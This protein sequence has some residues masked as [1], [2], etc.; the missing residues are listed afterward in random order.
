[1][2]E[3]DHAAEKGHQLC[4][5]CG[6]CCNGVIFADVKLQR[7]DNAEELRSLGVKLTA[8]PLRMG[9]GPGAARSDRH[10]LRFGQPCA[11]LEGCRCT[12]YAK[13]PAYCRDFECILLK[14]VND[15][16][17]SS[18]AALR[19][20]QDARKRAERVKSLLE[21]LGDSDLDQPLAA[22]FQRIAS[23]IHK[24]NLSEERAEL[25]GQLTLAVH[26]LNCLL[27][28]AFYR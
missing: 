10:T 25:Y 27:A 8:S 16:R 15:N 14:N 18:S 7:S 22:R 2:S 13:R 19:I 5:E 3:S 23:S 21:A 1:V 9:G 11:A 28:E 6:F 26:D 4:L 17:L 12:I 20:I 24:Q